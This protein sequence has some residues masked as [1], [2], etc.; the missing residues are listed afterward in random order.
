MVKL[1]SD[2]PGVAQVPATVTVPA[3]KTSVNFDV[4]TKPVSAATK[5]RITA[6][7][8]P[9]SKH[10]DLLVSPAPAQKDTV[11]VA[12]AELRVCDRELRVEATSTSRSARLEVLDKDTGRVIGTLTNEGDGKFKG[13]FKVN[14]LPK[15]I[16]VRSSLGGAVSVGVR[17]K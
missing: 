10:R 16:T 17:W 3:G 14:V 15:N 12:L 6:S 8:G 4:V 1:V 7:A 11:R 5:V 2:R 13:R 9:V